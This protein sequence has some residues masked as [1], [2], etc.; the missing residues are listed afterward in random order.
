MNLIKK[1]GSDKKIFA[2]E[3]I[4]LVIALLFGIAMAFVGTP[5]QEA[6]GWEHYV[7][8]LDVSYG[9]IF[10]P[11]AYINHDKGTAVVPGNFEEMNYRITAPSSG[12]G[13]AYKDYLKSIKL[14]KKGKIMDF[15]A[16]YASVFYYPQAIGL[17]IGRILGLSVY[18]CVVF[19]KIMNLIAFLVLVYTA[20]KI[21]PILKNTMIVIALF[22]MTI[23]QA[24]SFSYDSLLNGLC[25]LF[26]S[27]CFYYAYSDKEII[28][29]KEVLRL[30]ILLAFIFLCKYVYICIGLLVFLIP[31]EKF[32]SKKEYFK[33]FIIALI[34][35]LILGIFALFM[36]FSTFSSGQD[37]VKNGV[38]DGNTAMTPFEFLLSNPKHVILLLIITFINKFA[39]YMY[40]LDVLGSLNYSLGPLTYIVPMFALY[41][42]GSDVS[43]Y[44]YK[45]KLSDKIISL[46]TFVITSIIMVIGMYISDTR[47]NFAGNYVVQGIQGRYFIAILPAL[48]FA[49][50]PR[51]R[52]NEN[53][54]FSYE[55]LVCE[56]LILCFALYG[57][58]L[59]CY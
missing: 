25:F 36:A 28:S 54:Y 32:G 4:F 40:W 7:R 14:S 37:A 48:A 52:T 41:V 21:T 2:V 29:I 1:I 33:K 43:E 20:V 42:I 34:P 3:N 35:V 16:G 24:A 46:A 59:N 39:D 58:K 15:H 22:P 38:T 55:L 57:L 8:S 26:I 51:K 53:K 12:E 31:K 9:N 27:L 11:V 45:I 19:G 17:F 23:Y 18:G 30:G 13:T 6:D 49:L 10:A 44:G 47:I 5:F 56:F 50:V